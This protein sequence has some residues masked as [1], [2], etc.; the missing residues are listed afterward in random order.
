MR[1]PYEPGDS[2]FTQAALDKKRWKD[3]EAKVEALLRRVDELERVTSPH[4]LAG[5]D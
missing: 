4:Y 1:A 2:K 3:L 5:H